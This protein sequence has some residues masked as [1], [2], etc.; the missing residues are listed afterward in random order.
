MLLYCGVRGYFFVSSTNIIRTYIGKIDN[1]LT[2]DVL[3]NNLCDNQ[4]APL[5]LVWLNV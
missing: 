3:R 4:G 1:S 2:V 5:M